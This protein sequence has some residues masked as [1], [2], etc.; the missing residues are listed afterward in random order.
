MTRERKHQGQH[1]DDC[2]G[3]RIQTIGFSY[4]YGGRQAFKDND[5]LAKREK[6]AIEQAKQ[7]GYEPERYTG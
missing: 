6:R 7:G 4:P 5:S 1:G 2:F 3:C